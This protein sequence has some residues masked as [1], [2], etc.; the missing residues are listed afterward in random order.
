[1]SAVKFEM[2]IVLP[3]RDIIFSTTGRF[4]RPVSETWIL[5][6]AELTRWADVPQDEH[7]PGTI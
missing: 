6:S 4:D 2:E 7:E 5:A 3:G 1:M